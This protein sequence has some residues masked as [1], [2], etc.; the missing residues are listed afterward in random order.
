MN[1]AK[2]IAF[3]LTLFIFFSCVGFASGLITPAVDDNEELSALPKRM[4]FHT[5]IDQYT[6]VVKDNNEDKFPL[7]LLP[8]EL[9]V[10]IGDFLMAQD[11]QRF[12]FIEKKIRVVLMGQPC[13]FRFMPEG[14]KAVSAI[15]NQTPIDNIDHLASLWGREGYRRISKQ[16]FEIAKKNQSY[17]DGFGNGADDFK[18]ILLEVKLYIKC[19]RLMAFL[20]LSESR[21][22]LESLKDSNMTFANAKLRPQ[23]SPQGLSCIRFLLC[24]IAIMS[25]KVEQVINKEHLV[26]LGVNVDQVITDFKPFGAWIPYKIALDDQL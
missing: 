18:P 12:A 13:R 1:I 17:I 14:D 5:E 24:K 8:N 9:I 3:N 7:H 22:I 6:I 25:D 11:F 2:K 4:I 26:Q 16:L 15:L 23:E 19:H 10:Y 21:E 20:G